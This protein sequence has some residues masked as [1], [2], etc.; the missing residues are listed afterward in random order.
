MRFFAS[1]LP[2]VLVGL[3][4]VATATFGN[5]KD[6]KKNEF[7]WPN[8]SCCLPS[9][10]PPVPPPPPP[11]GI[12]CP[13]G[14]YW[15]DKQKCCVPKD[16]NPPGPSCPRDWVW[17][18]NLWKCLPKPSPPKPSPPK[19]QPSKRPGGGH[20]GGHDGRGKRDGPSW[21]SPCP[22][23]L[24]ACPILGLGEGDYECLDISAELTSCGGCSSE[25]S[26]QDCTSIPGVWNVGCVSGACQ[27]FTCTAGFEVTRDGTSCRHVQ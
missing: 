4:S 5:A 26:G 2:L 21:I 11:T 7:W 9:G 3:A 14:L 24:T 23:G 13:G 17:W 18:P 25:G 15:G 20:G 8:K 27:V 1:A 22:A 16:K 19:P 6:C 12:K 10:G